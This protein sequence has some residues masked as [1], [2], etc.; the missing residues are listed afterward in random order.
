MLGSK[1]G[2]ELAQVRPKDIAVLRKRLVCEVIE[3]S[4]QPYGPDNPQSRAVARMILKGQD[5]TDCSRENCDEAIKFRAKGPHLPV[6]VATVVDAAGNWDHQEYYYPPE[7]YDEVG[8]PYG[9]V[10][11]RPPE[12]IA[13]VPVA[14]VQGRAIADSSLNGVFTE[15]V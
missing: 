7:C 3:G 12:S 11:T 15:A 1:H 9:P 4:P 14:Q 10:Y 5:K 8:A 2:K 13:S 6:I